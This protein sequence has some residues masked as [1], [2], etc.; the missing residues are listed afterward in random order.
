MVCSKEYVDVKLNKN[1]NDF[2]F[3]L[4]TLEDGRLDQF[5]IFI[6]TNQSKTELYLTWKFEISSYEQVIL[7]GVL[8]QKLL[9][10]IF[11]DYSQRS[12]S[13][14][15]A[16]MRKINK[17]YIA[18]NT[19]SITL[20]LYSSKPDILSFPKGY[21]KEFTLENNSIGK[22]NILLYPK[23]YFDNY[24]IISCMN[25][26]TRTVY[27]NWIVKFSISPPHISKTV[28]VLCYL[29]AQTNIKFPF[30]NP[31]RRWAQLSFES[32]DEEL[33]SVV[34]KVVPFKAEEERYISISIMDQ[35]RPKRNEVLLFVSDEEEG[36]TGKVEGEL[37]QVVL[38]QIEYK[39]GE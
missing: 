38:F 28:K 1:T 7:N 23:N 17:Q 5:V 19:N 25:V 12:N 37:S 27:K 18:P 16:E 31:L 39:Y 11:I 14:Y 10:E 9:S 34:E 29:G 36:S 33:M 35:E 15:D 2:E 24:A 6:Y 22:S 26:Y 30:R 20:K 4:N 3:E 8:G 13:L 21:D 32:S